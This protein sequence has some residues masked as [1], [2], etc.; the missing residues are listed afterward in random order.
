MR[1]AVV[2]EEFHHPAFIIGPTSSEVKRGPSERVDEVHLR[3]FLDE[4]AGSLKTVVE[5]GMEQQRPLFFVSTVFFC[6]VCFVWL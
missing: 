5:D 3:A 6:F 2:E 1:S 4:N